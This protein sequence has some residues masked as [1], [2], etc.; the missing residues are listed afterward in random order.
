MQ[1]AAA[2]HPSQ[3]GDDRIVT[4]DDSVVVLDGASCF[5]A[6]GVPAATFVDTLSEELVHYLRSENRDL[7]SVLSSAIAAT[8]VRL[9]LRP[10]SAP[11]STVAMLRINQ[12]TV[13]TLVLGDS[14]AVV[15]TPEGTYDVVVD[16][17][18][19]QLDLLESRLYRNRLEAGAGYDAEHR[20]IL[21]ELQRK[22]RLNRNR[23]GG[24]WI[25]EAD[26]SAANHALVASY[27]RSQVSWI[28]LA[29]DG[30]A[31]MLAPLGIT[32][33]DVARLDSLG[34]AAVLARAHRWEADDDPHGQ[35]RPRAKRHDDKTVAVVHL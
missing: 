14:T 12:E 32:W 3:S 19:A 34:L 15:G 20:A 8:T 9:D 5:A 26:P 10:G 17:R 30:A 35:Q 2:Q 21:A 33:P 4:T 28:A 27:P 31:E 25:A 24:Y 29:T 11:S 13:E 23:D 1:V 6:D 7:P 16:D 18:L 22:E